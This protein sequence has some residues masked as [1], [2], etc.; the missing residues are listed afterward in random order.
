MIGCDHR[1]NQSAK[2]LGIVRCHFGNL[3]K[4]SGGALRVPAG[5]CFLAH[6][7]QRRNI[8]FL[9]LTAAHRQ[10]REQLVDSA[11]QLALAPRAG[12]VGDWLALKNRIDGRDRLHLELRGDK[13]ILVDI[14]FGQHH[15]LFG[16]GRRNFLEQR[17]QRLAWSAPF[18]PEIENDE[19]LHA[20]SHDLSLENFYRFLFFDCQS[21]CCHIMLLL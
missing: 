8:L 12:Q 11:G 3:R 1:T 7:Q 5:Q 18:C 4:N 9:L 21:C 20:R 6:R 10:L 17:R 15:A 19:L 13:F 2:R 16:I 14:D